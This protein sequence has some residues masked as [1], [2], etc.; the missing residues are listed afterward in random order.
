[1]DPGVA[2]NSLAAYEARLA[3]PGGALSRDEALTVKAIADNPTTGAPP[4][5]TTT[6]VGGIPTFETKR[7]YQ[8]ITPRMAQELQRHGIAMPGIDM[9]AAVGPA[10]GSPAQTPP[11]VPGATPAPGA[12]APRQGVSPSDA[13]L[14]GGVQSQPAPG[15]ELVARKAILDSDTYKDWKLSHNAAT[16]VVTALAKNNGYGDLAALQALQGALAAH[17]RLPH[18]GDSPELQKQTLSGLE[19]VGEMIK[20]V[21]TPGGARLTPE[22]QGYV[23]QLATSAAKNAYDSYQLETEPTRATYKKMGLDDTVAVPTIP[24]PPIYTPSAGAAAGA[25]R[26]APPATGNPLSLIRRPPPVIPAGP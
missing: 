26:T 7:D 25:T 18:L 5:T 21:S 8:P 4:K 13:T 2:R 16:N 10:G 22:Q 17:A 24:T 23:A 19:R 12:P 14:P 1:M 11:A 15:A 3:Q 20:Q 9:R 6:T